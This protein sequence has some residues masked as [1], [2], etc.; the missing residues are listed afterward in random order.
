MNRRG[1][2]ASMLAGT[3]AAPAWAAQG[4]QHGPALTGPLANATVSFG[5]WQSDPPFNRFPTN[6]DRF[7]NGHQLLP[8][9]VRIKAGGTV[10]FII[11][12]FHQVIVYAPGTEPGQID[13]NLVT[14]VTNPPGPPLIDDPA[15][16]VYRGIDPSTLPLLRGPM[17]APPTNLQDRVEVVH[18]A[19]PGRYLVICGVQP[20]FA[21]DGMF[22]FVTV[23]P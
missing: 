1:F 14:Q 15:N 19:S 21:V 23:L 3:V 18:F 7:R 5:F 13:T 9:E 12:G 16:R 17:D 10:N 11:G 2:F 20:H 6:N 4:H 22:G 8:H